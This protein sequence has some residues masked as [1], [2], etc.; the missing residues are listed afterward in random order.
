M[1]EFLCDMITP[2]LPVIYKSLSLYGITSIAAGIDLIAGI[3]KSRKRGVVLV[4]SYGIKKTLD[5]LARYFNLLLAASTLDAAMI[6]SGIPQAHGLPMLPYITT[7]VTVIFCIVES[8]SVWEKDE[9]KGK[10][11]EAAK[12][13]KEA[14]KGVDMDDFTEKLISKLKELEANENKDNNS[15]S[16]NIPNTSGSDNVSTGSTK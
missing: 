11:L 10:Y 2:Y 13:A 7:L 14:I 8:Y 15:T 9:D 3:R 6:I 12:I 16:G 4:H 1:K 5:K